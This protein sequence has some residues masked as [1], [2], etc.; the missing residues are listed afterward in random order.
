MTFP[1]STTPTTMTPLNGK[2]TCIYLLE[3]H[4]KFC[5]VHHQNYIQGPLTIP[6]FHLSHVTRKL[7]SFNASFNTSLS[8]GSIP[9]CLFLIPVQL[10]VSNALLSQLR[11]DRE[12]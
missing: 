1:S 6:V 5:L 12:G 4:L 9:E 2:H 7:F 8:H 11:L 3:V 10:E